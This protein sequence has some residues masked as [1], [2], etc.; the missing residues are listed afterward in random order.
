MPK[1]TF[2]VFILFLSLTQISFAKRVYPVVPHLNV[3]VSPEKKS[4]VLGKL[5]RGV[6]VKKIKRSGDWIKI[7]GDRLN[8]Y[9]FSKHTSNRWIKV[10]KKERKLLLMEDRKTIRSYPIA[11]GFNP[12]GDKTKL[13]DG[14]TPTG[15]FYLC[16]MIKK[17]SR[18][19]YGARSMRISYPERTDARRG[20]GEKL[21]KKTHYEDII[22]AIDRAAIPPQN[23]GL[24]GSIRIHGGGSE[25]DWTLGCI[26][27]ED[28]DIIKLY[29]EVPVKNCRIEIYEDSDH[30]R[31]VN[32]KNRMGLKIY[33]GAGNIL[34]MGCLYTQSATR[35]IGMDFPMGDISPK[36]GVC[37]DVVI[38]SLRNAGIDLQAA[39]YEDIMLRPEKY[40]WI[41]KRDTNIDHR[42]TKNLNVWFENN[43]INLST[44]K[45]YNGNKDWLPGDIVIMDTGVRNGTIY[46]HIGIVGRKRKNGIPHVIN[47][48]T[49]GSVIEE[50]NLLGY[51]Y[52]KVVGHY[53]IETHRDY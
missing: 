42:R 22:K 43:S 49:I 17:P 10:L 28:R 13:G 2:T 9:I 48:W 25:K 15:I 4:R 5:E 41:R 19:K 44:T 7:E 29:S 6:W 27:M 26:G 46:D 31:R 50:M 34:K 16:E 1:T 32:S 23:T 18:A 47:L 11:L 37:T 35:V 51:S 21:I 38:R 53:R 12:V 52:P 3:R 30:F 39:I 36:I 40:P 14:K 20:L 33:E 8:G 24:G 45:P